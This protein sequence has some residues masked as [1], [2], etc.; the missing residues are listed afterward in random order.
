MYD[1]ISEQYLI[2]NPRFCN[3]CKLTGRCWFLKELSIQ[4]II[5]FAFMVCSIM[6]SIVIATSFIRFPYVVR[7]TIISWLQYLKS[8]IPFSVECNIC[9]SIN[10]LFIWNSK[11][12]ETLALFLNSD[13]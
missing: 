8:V 6:L 13:I 2:S 11:F 12:K 9:C 5:R 10:A 7:D 1:L 3:N 4:S